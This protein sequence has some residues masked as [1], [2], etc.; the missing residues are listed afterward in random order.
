V[1][2]NRLRLATLWATIPATLALAGCGGAPPAGVP[3]G[4]VAAAP[5]N[6]ASGA[7]PPD[8]TGL[9]ARMVADPNDL[10]ALAG[11]ARI[12]WKDGRHEEAVAA[13]E[14]ARAAG[15]DLPEEMLAAL[16][17][18][19][20]A[21]GRMADADSL[22]RRLEGRLADWARGG[23]AVTYLKLRGGSFASTEA[24]ARRALE[25]SPSAANHNNLGI[26]LLYAGR[27]ADARKS[28]LTAAELDGRLPGPL[29]NL[30]IVDRFYRFDDP[31]ARE[32]FR[33]YRTLS[34]DDPDGLAEAL[35]VEIASGAKGGS[36]LE[37]DR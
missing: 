18:H 14:G 11:L 4:P 5:A 20:D 22:T 2:R 6:S 29:Y 30:A 21:L 36:L 31:S 7:S 8:E 37:E 33:R 32:W 3:A 12:L 10:P 24:I 28:F 15:A 1:I 17:L 23:S 9:R 34:S 19:Y 25:A 26:A 16:A 27:P 13:I 35:S